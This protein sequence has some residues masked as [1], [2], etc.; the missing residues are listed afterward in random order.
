MKLISFVFFFMAAS[1]T[2][3][4]VYSKSVSSVYRRGPPGMQ[5]GDFKETIENDNMKSLRDYLSKPRHYTRIKKRSPHHKV[6]I[7]ESEPRKKTCG[8]M[9]KN[10]EPIGILQPYEESFKLIPVKEQK[11]DLEIKQLHSEDDSGP[12]QDNS[13]ALSDNNDN[14]KSSFT[15]RSADSQLESNVEDRLKDILNEMGLIE[16]QNLD[17][18]NEK[19]YVKEDENLERGLNK[20]NMIKEN[21]DSRM[22][23]KRLVQDK[24]VPV[25]SNLLNDNEIFKV[26]P[27]HKRSD[28]FGNGERKRLIQDVPVPVESNLL[29][30]NDIFVTSNLLK[31]EVKSEPQKNDRLENGDRGDYRNKRHEDEDNIIQ[32][33]ANSGDLSISGN[34]SP[35]AYAS[36]T[37]MEEESSRSSKREL[38]RRKRGNPRV[39]PSK[40]KRFNTLLDVETDVLNPVL[41]TGELKPKIRRRR[42]VDRVNTIKEDILREISEL[43]N[44]PPFTS[45]LSTMNTEQPTLT[46]NLN[47][48]T[49][50]SKNTMNAS[51]S[52]ASTKCDCSTNSMNTTYNVLVSTTEGNSNLTKVVSLNASDKE[53]NISLQNGHQNLQISINTNQSSAANKT[54]REAAYPEKIV[55]KR[56]ND[57]SQFFEI[58]KD[59]EPR[60][61]EETYDYYEEKVD[62]VKKR[63][64]SGNCGRDNTGESCNCDSPGCNCGVKGTQIKVSREHN[65][66]RG[67][68]KR[69]DDQISQAVFA[70]YEDE[71]DSKQP[72]IRLIRSDY[73]MDF[74]PD[75][76]NMVPFKPAIVED[77]DDYDYVNRKGRQ[78]LDGAALHGGVASRGHATSQIPVGSPYRVR[79]TID[80]KGDPIKLIDMSDK[81]IFGALPQSFEGELGT[82][83]RP[84]EESYKLIPVKGLKENLDVVDEKPREKDEV[85]EE[86]KENEEEKEDEEF[87]N[88]IE[89]NGHKTEKIKDKEKRTALKQPVSVEEQLRGMLDEIGS[90]N[91]LESETREKR[92]AQENSTREGIKTHS[93]QFKKSPVDKQRA[94]RRLNFL[95][96]SVKLRAQANTALKAK[97]DERVNNHPNNNNKRN[98]KS[99]KEKSSGLVDYEKKVQS[100]I[101]K[102]IQALK[103]EVKREIEYLKGD[104]KA[105]LQNTRKKREVDEGDGVDDDQVEGRNRRQ[106]QIEYYAPSNNDASDTAEIS[107]ELPSHKNLDQINPITEPPTG[108]VATTNDYRRYIVNSTDKLV[109][110]NINNGKHVNVYSKRKRQITSEDLMAE[111]NLKEETQNI[112]RD[113]SSGKCGKNNEGQSCNCNSPGCNCGSGEN[114]LTGFN[115]DKIKEKRSED[116]EEYSFENEFD[117]ED[118]SDQK[119]ALRRSMSNE[120]NPEYYIDLHPD[121]YHIKNYNEEN[122]EEVPDREKR[123]DMDDLVA[124]HGG[125]ATRNHLVAIRSRSMGNGLSRVRRRIDR[126]LDDEPIHLIDMSDEDIFGALPQSF[127]GELGRYKR[128]KR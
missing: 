100:Q 71:L 38:I 7:H 116:A 105:E 40:N 60:F 19:R 70:E 9:F 35:L 120:D 84:F 6:S 82:Y 63:C 72:I 33:L 104:D 128:I 22:E 86:E 50:I 83:K 68:L 18:K 23:S 107:V 96:D 102:K 79:R 80:E 56:E 42:G 51:A 48:I 93:K 125:T 24:P 30:D 5:Y 10:K 121:I 17:N 26:R 58:E 36:N 113:C 32:D 65:D 119:S 41:N 27:E 89:K 53:I 117:Y 14:I 28:R 90:I 81:E 54:K 15:K 103:D 4:I 115:E 74:H 1:F 67:D 39:G 43:N 92:F 127:E 75:L 13:E 112:K 123:S 99:I 78:S 110:I 122:Y 57:N 64:S 97:N 111:T 59:L 45:S 31:R 109:K 3:T 76:Y 44:L 25:E 101:Q 91:D 61:A 85:T 114:K 2:I 106:V 55:H 29:N 108:F 21:R 77:G 118:A 62:N 49:C 52:T 126:D 124:L 88:M 46:G 66:R 20:I 34:K 98:K 12:V 73:Y 37:V 47:M 8:I 95:L 69:S 94:E 11:I 87:M 16:K